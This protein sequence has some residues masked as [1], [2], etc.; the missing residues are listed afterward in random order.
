MSREIFDPRGRLW[1]FAWFYWRNARATAR[2][3]GKAQQEGQGANR[4]P[5][6]SLS[7]IF[8]RGDAGVDGDGGGEFMRRDGPR[9][10]LARFA[11]G[12]AFFYCV[13][14]SSCLQRAYFAKKAG[15]RS[16]WPRDSPRIPVS[17][18]AHSNEG[19]S[20]LDA[21]A[22]RPREIS[23]AEAFIPR[24]HLGREH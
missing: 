2:M 1:I 21:A 15:S 16:G 19:S 4:N 23:M 20:E 5:P 22:F 7:A 12:V 18:T 14:V 10:R 8:S 11:P 9:N 13:R 3:P 24:G 6:R 17:T